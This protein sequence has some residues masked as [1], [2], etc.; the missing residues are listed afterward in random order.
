MLEKSK[1]TLI[2]D[3]EMRTRVRDLRMRVGKYNW[4]SISSHCSL[5]MGSI[6]EY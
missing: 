1:K 6:W 2:E 3:G 5:Y 4:G